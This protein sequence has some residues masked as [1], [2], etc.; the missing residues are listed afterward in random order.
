MCGGFSP[1]LALRQAQQNQHIHSFEVR[2]K[3]RFPLLVR[4]IV[5]SLSNALLVTSIKMIPLTDATLIYSTVPVFTAFIAHWKLKEHITRQDLIIMGA[6]FVGI[7]LI[8]LDK[9]HK[10]TKQQK[11]ES[12][13]DNLGDQTEIELNAQAQALHADFDNFKY[14]VGALLALLAAITNAIAFVSIKVMGKRV[15]CLWSPL[16]W[17]LCNLFLSPVYLAVECYLFMGKNKN[18][19]ELQDEINPSNIG[20]HMLMGYTGLMIMLIAISQ[21]VNMIFSTMAHQYEKASK[22]APF[23]YTSILIVIAIDYLFLD[24]QLGWMQ[25]VGGAIILFSNLTVSIMKCATN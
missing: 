15:H 12:P 11:S 13:N 20:M 14:H 2:Q 24:T 22:T 21:L 23:A 7:V 9:T 17:T 8:N 1:I 16:S 3:E 5:G 18:D 6:A 4:G 25:I 19:A 10:S